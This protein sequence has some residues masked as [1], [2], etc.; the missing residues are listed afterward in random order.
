[1]PYTTNDQV[2]ALVDSL[3][4]GMLHGTM[5]AGMKSDIVTAVKAV[6]ISNPPTVNQ[7]R[8]RVHTAIYLIATSSQYQ[9][10]Q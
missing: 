4:N 6:T 5:S 8:K 1:L 10:Q 3:N 9:V 2:S 7:Q